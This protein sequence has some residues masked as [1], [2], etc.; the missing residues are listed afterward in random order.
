MTNSICLADNVSYNNNQAAP[1]AI[2]DPHKQAEDVI[3]E[4]ADKSVKMES[5]DNQEVI[6]ENEEIETKKEEVTRKE[7][8]VDIL[9]RLGYNINENKIDDS[10]S[11]IKPAQFLRREEVLPRIDEQM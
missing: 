7:N 9:A 4:E 8:P 3:N 10:Y 5:L 1:S 11:F 2:V 6:Q